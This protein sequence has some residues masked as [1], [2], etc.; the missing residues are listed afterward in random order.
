MKS[1][2][3]YEDNELISLIKKG[4]NVEACLEEITSRHEKLFYKIIHK[5][6]Y[7]RTKECRSDFIKDKNLLFYNIC[8]DFKCD[9]KSKFTTFFYNRLKWIL[10]KDYQIFKKKFLNQVEITNEIENKKDFEYKENLSNI[11]SEVDQAMDFIKKQKDERILK[12]FTLRYLNGSGNKLMPWH[13]VCKKVDLSIQGCIDVHNNF[14][15]KISKR[16]KD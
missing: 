8:L 4:K 1:L 3:D 14:L 6:T 13:Q 15:K 5:Y 2:K 16:R 7:F 12:I 10:I 11:S 9:K